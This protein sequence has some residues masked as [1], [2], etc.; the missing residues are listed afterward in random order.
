MSAKKQKRTKSSK[1]IMH[2]VL[3]HTNWSSFPQL[4]ALITAILGLISLS[5]CV[6]YAPLLKSFLPLEIEMEI[7]LAVSLMLAS[8]ALFLLGNRNS[9]RSHKWALV[10]AFIIMVLGVA[11]LAKTLF[12]FNFGIDKI[13]PVDSAELYNTKTPR[14]SPIISIAFILVG[15]TIASLGK[16]PLITLARLISFM[17]I[18]I[19]GM[20]LLGHL[21]NS[22][23]LGAS[24]WLTPIATST[25]SAITL[26]GAGLF[27]ASFPSD[28][29]KI[30]H[31]SVESRVLVGF[32]G[33]FLLLLLGAGYTYR[34]VSEFA[35]NAKD[36][37]HI[38]SIRTELRQLYSEIFEVE[39][40]H[41]S[42][43]LTAQK[44]RKDDYER[45]ILEL[46][47]H[48][49]KLALLVVDTPLQLINNTELARLI[50][51]RISN[52]ANIVAIFEK[53]G[54][55]AAG[56]AILID[57][58][59]QTLIAIRDQIKLMDEL[60]TQLL[61]DQEGVMTKNRQ[62][63]LVSLLATISVAVV[64]LALLFRGI[65]REIVA[66]TQ[67][68]IV[69]KQAKEKAEEA[70]HALNIEKE[71]AE[72]VNRELNI[73]K[74][75]AE[76][77]NHAL[78]IEKENAEQANR[79]LKIEKI[80]A[81]EANH[82]KDS[83]LAIMS[84]EIRT[85]LAGMLGMLE[86]LSLTNIDKEQRPTLDAAW[87]SGRGL[88]RIVNDIL[89][90]SKIEEGK[91]EISLHPTSINQLLSEV[92]NTYSSVA[93]SKSL[94]LWQHVDP[95][96]SAVHMVD[97][98]RLSQILNNLVSN[99][100][101]FT[102]LGEVEIR[103]K[104]IEKLYDGER[105]RFS[106]KDTG[107][108]I[109]KEAQQNLFERYQQENAD[110]ARMYGGT[111]L[112]LSICR[113]LAELM[114]GEISLESNPGQGSTF[115]I[116][117]TLS[118]TSAPA[119]NIS[120]LSPYIVKRKVVPLSN[121]SEFSPLIL[122]VDDHPI[123]R[124]M[125]ARQIRI[126]GL[127]VE[128]AEDGKEALSMWREG[129]FAMVITDCHMPHMDGYALSKAI[130]KIEMEDHLAYT[131]ILAWTANPLAEEEV[132]CRAAGMDELLTKPVDLEQMKKMLAKWLSIT[133]Y[134]N[135]PEVESSQS[136]HVS[137]LKIP[138]D[139]SIL[140]KVVPDKADQIQLLLDFQKTINEDFAELIEVLKNGDYEKVAS[141]A[142]RIKGSCQMIGAIDMAKISAHIEKNAEA[143]NLVEV[144]AAI[145]N[146][147]ESKKLVEI[148]C[149]TLKV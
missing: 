137:Q 76:E 142:H 107:I 73:E 87:D 2:L 110:I 57:D 5:G 77:A 147:V 20:V 66:R 8:C 28:E 60:E 81:E 98:L 111:G 9:N 1:V 122:A 134:S 149:K 64:M 6:F 44:L 25:A 128:V 121:G 99:A 124:D 26:I 69:A 138:I 31:L 105:V 92:V 88:L 89:D 135:I 79:A 108:G 16:F 19:G 133:Q 86:L 72:L 58:E 90:W 114:N 38:Q 95:R 65:R 125:L 141:M 63:T 144:H 10:L 33:A 30:K 54:G 96:L 29:L 131:P 11:T 148:F 39:S 45:A 136:I 119:E 100:I 82:A 35:S 49:D 52:L 145:P 36:T 14:M 118:V 126:L 53:E 91:L 139:Y 75:R 47:K 129:R 104:L 32:I 61:A 62:N 71:I 140:K 93:N 113:S 7:N 146:F 78:N 120:S 23:E 21:W 103:A 116:T 27:L 74:V 3:R 109:P 68:E 55:S 102:Q 43:L 70:L 22:N 4:V 41:R 59:T 83:F 40:A 127:R 18:A 46:H 15:M 106:V 13:L 143:N 94:T 115:S 132:R 42:Y 117:I 12:G 56:K 48:K 130:R 101:K 34:K 80:K 50:A 84:H 97:A 112:G 37:I 123:N 85:P 67:A 51:H 24:I 17:I